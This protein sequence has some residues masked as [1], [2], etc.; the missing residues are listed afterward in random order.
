MVA[1]QDEQAIWVRSPRDGLF[2]K[3]GEAWVWRTVDIATDGVSE[4]F[5]FSSELDA[6]LSVVSEQA[7]W[8][9]TASPL[10]SVGFVSTS[11]QLVD[12]ERRPWSVTLTPAFAPF[13]EAVE[14]TGWE[15]VTTA[16]EGRSV[17]PGCPGGFG[18]LG[19]F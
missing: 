4:P 6:G 12:V 15:N 8:A 9:V 10:A 19:G 5:R 7:L 16:A 18:G 1:S 11:D 3:Y 13:T 14:V 17:T 2:D